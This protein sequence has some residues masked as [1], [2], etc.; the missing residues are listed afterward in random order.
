[1]DSMCAEYQ[2]GFKSC[3]NGVHQF[4]Q[5]ADNSNGVL[6]FN[7]LRHL[8]DHLSGLP[9]W[10][11]TADSDEDHRMSSTE[12]HPWTPVPVSGRD[13]NISPLGDPRSAEK[14]RVQSKNQRHLPCSRNDTDAPGGLNLL[15]EHRPAT[16]Q[17][18]WRPWWNP[19]CLK[20]A[21]GEYWLSGRKGRT[22]T[23]ICLIRCIFTPICSV[24]L[25]SW[26]FSKTFVFEYL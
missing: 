6:R 17:C 4:L 12:P 9:S 21:Y 2:E 26:A 8:S 25:S 1:M 11:S 23:L 3:L 13:C 22:K 24:K 19:E 5:T 7:V 16:S 15:K 20:I 10:S 18:Y 14:F